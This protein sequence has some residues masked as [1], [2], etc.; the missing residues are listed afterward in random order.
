[1]A[2]A[3]LELP[4]FCVPPLGPAK[5]MME[6][7]CLRLLESRYSADLGDESKGRVQLWISALSL[8]ASLE[9]DNR[10]KLLTCVVHTEDMMPL[11]E[12]LYRCSV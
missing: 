7:V 10:W 11:S 5:D 12:L 1:V 3:L 6:R 2:F 8:K 9:S 4:A